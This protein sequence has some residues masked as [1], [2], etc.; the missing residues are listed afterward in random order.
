MSVL[1]FAHLSYLLNVWLGKNSMNMQ[2]LD[3]HLVLGFKTIAVVIYAPGGWVNHPLADLVFFLQKVIAHILSSLG[4][5]NMSEETKMLT[6]QNV[7]VQKIMFFPLARFS[8]WTPS[9][10]NTVYSKQGVT[11]WVKGIFDCSKFSDVH[12]YICVTD[13]FMKILFLI[14]ISSNF[15]L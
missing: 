6:L 7:V 5:P 10:Y 8:Y 2:G 14:C 4:M 1:L 12:T 13:I 11:I 9:W 15:L 3:C